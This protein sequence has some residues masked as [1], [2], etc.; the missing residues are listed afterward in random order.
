MIAPV[1]SPLAPTRCRQLTTAQAA[2]GM[3]EQGSP[4]HSDF[5][6]AAFVPGELVTGEDDD[7]GPDLKQTADLLFQGDGELG[8]VRVRP[9]R[10]MA[11]SNAT[12]VRT[13]ASCHAH[14]A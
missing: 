8:G 9:A 1:R 11:R 7:A 13:S 4:H 10:L 3:Q 14:R 6:P 2:R 12:W 5:V